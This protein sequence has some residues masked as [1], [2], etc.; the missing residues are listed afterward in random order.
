MSKPY[1]SIVMRSMNDIKF[2]GR[3]LDSVMSQS[4]K[5]FELVNI[6]SGSTDGTFDVVKR[7][8]PGKSRQIRPEEYI[9]GKVLN[10]AVKSCSGEIVVFN[11]SDCIPLDNE[12]LENLI[13]PFAKDEKIGATFANQLPRPDAKPL[14][15]RDSL[16]AYGDGSISAKWHHFFS[17]ASSAAP[18]KILD[19]IPF[20]ETIKYSEDIEWSLRIKKLGWKIVYVPSSKVEH[21]H[22]Y[23]LAELRKRFYNEGLAEGRIYGSSTC[24]TRGF[25]QPMLSA[26]TRDL[27]CLLKSGNISCIPSG[28][29]YRFI[30]KYYA[31]KGRKDYFRKK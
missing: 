15:A 1:V 24:F 27:A 17:L 9:P 19:E 18:K 11:N 10:S 7:F 16:R 22:N 13:A 12:W 4:F 25:C 21:S 5:D 2:I 3:T 14:V 6:D 20:D 30:Q 29:N 28:L 26:V 8:N 23:T 31:Y